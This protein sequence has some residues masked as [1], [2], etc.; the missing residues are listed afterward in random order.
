MSV[1]VFKGVRDI[2]MEIER[3][4]EMSKIT[5]DGEAIQMLKLKIPYVKEEY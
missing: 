5:L 2:K 1:S 4:P 3:L